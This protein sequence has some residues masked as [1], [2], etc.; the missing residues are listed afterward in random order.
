M[1][2]ECYLYYEKFEN[3]NIST[4]ISK[5]FIFPGVKPLPNNFSP[6]SKTQQ[7]GYDKGWSPQNH[8]V[9]LHQQA[10]SWRKR[11]FVRSDSP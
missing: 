8:P 9:Q 2:V 1:S 10:S 5:D 11:S 4:S 3:F 7:H 6:R